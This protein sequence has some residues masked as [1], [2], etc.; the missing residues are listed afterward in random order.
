MPPILVPN[1]DDKEELAYHIRNM[2]FITAGVATVLF[3]LVIFGKIESFSPQYISQM[4]LL[5]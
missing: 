3:I 2:F 4:P 5:C 1:V